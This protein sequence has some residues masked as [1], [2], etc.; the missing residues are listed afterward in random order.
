MRTLKSALN[1]NRKLLIDCIITGFVFFLLSCNS[2]DQ[3]TGFIYCDEGVPIRGLNVKIYSDPGQYPENPLAVSTTRSNGSFKF[4]AIEG[5]S[6]M[7]EIEGTHGKGRVNISSVSLPG[8]FE[9]TYPINEKIVILHTND[10]HFDL[11]NLE[12]LQQKIEEIRNKYDDVFLFSAGDLFVR[13][14]IR[15]IV[16]GELIEDNEWYGERCMEMINSLNNLGYDLLTLGNHELCYREPYTR[17]ALEAANFPLLSANMEIT[18]DALPPVND[19]AIL[20]T[21][22]WRKIAV[23]GLSVCNSDKVGVKERDFTETVNKYI[24][25]KDS[26]DVFVAL[27]HIGLRRDR[28]LAADY[29]LFDVIVGGHSHSLLPESEFVNSVLIAHAGGN[30][31]FVSDD[32]PVYLGKI[33]LSLNNGFIKDKKGWLIEIVPEFE[34]EKIYT[35]DEAV[36]E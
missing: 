20:N 25:L 36:I 4:S 9:I 16:N 1:L 26:S 18:T 14:P 29:P 22:T 17:I 30:V 34:P 21:S 6:Y 3:L 7:L 13:N 35:L 23:L 15:W 5:Q 8:N 19:Y 10:H 2:E 33:V 31:H 27:T 24:S 12:E 32:H 28:I 11:N